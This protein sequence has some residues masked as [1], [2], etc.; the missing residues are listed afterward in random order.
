MENTDVKQLWGVDFRVV[1]QG[2]A[3]DEVV[4]F[5]DKLMKES[6]TA[7]DE[8]ERAASLHRLAEQ[9]VVEADKLAES[10]KQQATEE[11]EEAAARIAAD[12]EEQATVQSQRII[13][14]AEREAAA[15]SNAAGS[16]SEKE[17]QEVIARARAEVQ[18]ILQDARDK[19][20]SMEAEA[21]LEAEYLIRRMTVK[22]V[23]EI[24][25]VVTETSNNLLPSLEAEI[26]KSGETAMLSDGGDAQPAIAPARRRPKSSSS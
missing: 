26:S 22:F 25:S 14:K 3:E 17:A 23:E 5:V 13:K 18:E 10:I 4:S 9:T 20:V 19:V 7:G 12:S 1:P 2:L 16:K 11:A 8:Q 24:R 15:L 6:R 21:K